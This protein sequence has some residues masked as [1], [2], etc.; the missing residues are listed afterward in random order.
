MTNHPIHLHGHEFVVVG[1]DGGWT[2]PASRWP[3]VTTD[4]AVGQMRAIEFTAAA[5][6]DWAF[7]CHKS[8]H[9]MNAMS[10]AL[11]NT[12]GV[13]QDDLAKQITSL[14]PGYMSTGNEMSNM[15]TSMPLPENTL[16]MM[17]G[18]GP[19]GQIEMGGM[20]TVMKIRANLAHGDYRDPGWYQAP[21]GS[22]AHAWEGE[23]PPA[24]RRGAA[25]PAAA[26][27]APFKVRKP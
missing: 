25:A 9:T 16:P 24:E 13:E 4:I 5:P 10:H 6:G 23:P 14:V 8:H 17:S 22:V 3:E 12:L 21:A 19:Y 27:S 20:F 26:E 15:Q 1:T 18:L 7:H 2:S 11:P